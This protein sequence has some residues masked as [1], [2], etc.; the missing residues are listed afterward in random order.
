V[1]LVVLPKTSG[2]W[3][4]IQVENR[5]EKI[6]TAAVRVDVE[7]GQVVSCVSRFDPE[8]RH[9]AAGSAGQWFEAIDAGDPGRLRLGGGRRLGEALVRG[10]HGALI[11][12]EV[13]A[14]SLVTN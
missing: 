12:N 14:P 6:R 13:A 5:D 9:W 4:Q 10:L 3:C 2:G 1:P 7:A 11:E 8:A